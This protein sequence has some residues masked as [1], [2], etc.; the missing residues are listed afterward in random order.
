M[1]WKR[2]VFLPF[3]KKRTFQGTWQAQSTEHV[4]LDLRVVSSSLRLGIE[5]TLKKRERREFLFV[6]LLRKFQGD[7]AGESLASGRN[8]ESGTSVAAPKRCDW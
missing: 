8:G 4:T 7:T 6:S 5:L 2:Q 3:K 1:H